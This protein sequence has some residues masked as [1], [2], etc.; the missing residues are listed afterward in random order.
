MTANGQE[1]RNRI[2]A[3]QTVEELREVCAEP[4][5]KVNAEEED[6][7]MEAKAA[8]AELTEKDLDATVGGRSPVV[9]IEAMK[10][11]LKEALSIKPDEVL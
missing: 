3:V 2:A 10:R 4:G 5:E 11:T 6:V 1:A 8:A 9:D 7:L